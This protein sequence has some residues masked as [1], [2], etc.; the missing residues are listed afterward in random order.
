MGEGIKENYMYMYVP[1]RWDN[2][3]AFFIRRKRVE[4]TGHGVDAFSDGCRSP[5]GRIKM[6][7][8]CLIPDRRQ[9]ATSVALA[10]C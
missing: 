4:G 3:F 5:P 8:A 10:R 1:C 6:A 2:F 7:M 9:Q